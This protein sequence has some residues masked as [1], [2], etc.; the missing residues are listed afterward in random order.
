VSFALAYSFHCHI[1]FLNQNCRSLCTKQNLLGVQ[2]DCPHREKIQYGGDILADSPAAMHFYDMSAFYRKVVLDWADQQWDNGAY[3]GT[4]YWLMLNDQTGIGNGSGETVWAS[5]PVVMTARHMQHYGD[6]E[7]LER[8]LDKHYKWLAFLHKHFDKGMLEKGY[9]EELEDYYKSG[10]G[11]GD[12]LS[13]RQR[14]TWLTHEGFY[15]ASARSIAYIAEKLGAKDRELSTALEI[16]NLVK[17]RIAELYLKYNQ[18]FLPPDSRGKFMSPAQEMGLFS[19]IVPGDRRCK[20][21]RHYFTRIGHTWPGSAEKS[22]LNHIDKETKESMK[23]SGEVTKRTPKMD[24]MGWSQWHG[25]NEGIFSVRYALKTLSETGYHNVALDKANGFGVGTWEYMLSHNATTHWESWWRSED[26]YSHNHP[27]LGASAEW[28]VS[29][30]AGLELEPTTTG[31][32]EV[33][34]WPRFPNS[35]NTLKYAGA[36]QGTRRGDFA[37]AWEFVDLPQD[38]TLYNSASVQIHIRAYVPPDG[39]AVLRLPEYRNGEGVDSILKKALVLP[40]MDQA[41]L[42]SD[43]D[44]ASRRE[45]KQHGFGYNWEFDQNTM[46]WTKF[47]R[48]KSIG[49][50]CRH[51]LFHSHLDN[52]EWDKPI[53]APGTSENGVEVILAPGLYD[54]VVNDWQL[55]PEVKQT[56]QEWRIG[57]RKEYYEL[58]D[59]GPYCSDSDSFDWN[60]GDASHLI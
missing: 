59:L 31:G 39:E 38:K 24:A 20:V 25:F 10:S 36:T 60:I 41:K 37:I 54:V 13:F 57:D 14:D 17:D 1:S 47:N 2:S 22:F 7:F 8:T 29:A 52:V 4:S 27:M 51:F 6:L 58:E 45:S 32:K 44:C 42:L 40:D 3:A 19:R 34:F 15:M 49:T 9:H 35:A 30:V 12:W 55:T 50:P 26:L 21:L 46:L 53:A 56:N 33:Q 28:M 23:T 18:G 16:S 11:L 43:D 48:T 5:A